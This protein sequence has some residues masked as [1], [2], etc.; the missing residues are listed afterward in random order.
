MNT[1][2]KTVIPFESSEFEYT[3]EYT[4]LLSQLT[5]ASRQPEGMVDRFENGEIETVDIEF[6]GYII[7][8]FTDIDSEVADNLSVTQF[9]YLVTATMNTIVGEETESFE[10]FKE[11]TEIG[12]GMFM[13]NGSLGVQ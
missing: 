5:L 4:P 11:E 7:S 3:V 8:N 1:I 12:G 6:L 9:L 2:E 10:Q 13:N